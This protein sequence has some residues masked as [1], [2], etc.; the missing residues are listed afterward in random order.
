MLPKEIR[1]W[2]KQSRR[3]SLDALFRF[4]GLDGHPIELACFA[5]GQHKPEA[6]KYSPYKGMCVAY[7][8]GGVEGVEAL[9]ALGGDDEPGDKPLWGTGY[10][11]VPARLRPGVEARYVPEAWHVATNG[12]ASEKDAES[13]NVLVIDVDPQRPD[14][15][16]SD[17]A[18]Y[19]G[20]LTL[21]WS[22]RNQL[23]EL[24]IPESALA[25]GS[26]GNGCHVVMA[27]TGSWSAE[28]KA[29]RKRLLDLLGVLHDTAAYH[30]DPAMAD[31]ARYIPLYGT[32]KKKGPN[33]GERVQRRSFLA[34]PSEVTRL[35]LNELLALNERLLA[36][37][38]LDQSEALQQREQKR[39]GVRAP[40][41][42]ADESRTD[43]A[44]DRCNAVSVSTVA[45]ELGIDPDAPTCPACGAD[46]GIDCLE[47]KGRNIIKCQHSTC[48]ARAWSPVAL[49]MHS[50]GSRPSR[51]TRKA[52]RR[53]CRGSRAEG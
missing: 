45:V 27:F 3:T 38:S 2:W 53:S 4:A 9:I 22:I 33:V 23:V 47:A 30:V 37:L 21:G 26:S 34:V 11:L 35:G 51:G 1:E 46:K 10:Y 36:G 7:T 13:C 32:M 12:T 48:G 31:G 20:S 41:G 43:R 42:A 44:L 24:G 15:T 16:N 50:L 49:V 28:M 40:A 29:A 17:K 5:A 8:T 18:E 19:L 25:F 14:G 39:P 52:R 6:S